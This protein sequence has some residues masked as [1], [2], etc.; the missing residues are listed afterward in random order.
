MKINEITQLRGQHLFEA[1]DSANDTGVATADL[2]R[3][4]DAHRQNVWSAPVDVDAYI[5]N[6]QEGALAWQKGSSK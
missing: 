1:L 6:L 3:V 5:K 2:V 4:V